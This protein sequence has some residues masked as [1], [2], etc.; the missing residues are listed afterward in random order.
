[1]WKS[2]SC[3]RH[4]KIHNFLEVRILSIAEIEDD[5]SSKVEDGEG[6][7]WGGLI[8]LKIQIGCAF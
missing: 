3:R 7:G 6:R 5:G 4:C 2:G 8:L 1:M